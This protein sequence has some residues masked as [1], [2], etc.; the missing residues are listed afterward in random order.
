M[1]EVNAGEYAKRKYEQ[2]GRLAQIRKAIR[3]IRQVKRMSERARIK[4]MYNRSR[5]VNK[6][7]EKA[8]RN[9]R[10]EQKKLFK[11]IT[12][13]ANTWAKNSVALGSFDTQAYKK[14]RQY[15]ISSLN[16]A[17][18]FATKNT[19]GARVYSAGRGLR[20]TAADFLK[21]RHR[22]VKRTGRFLRDARMSAAQAARLGALNSGSIFNRPVARG[23]SLGMHYGGNSQKI[24]LRAQ[25]LAE[26][27]MK[28]VGEYKKYLEN[29]AKEKENRLKAQASAARAATEG[30]LGN[31]NR[32]AANLA[33][34][35]ARAAALQA[36]AQEVA[37]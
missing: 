17:A 8:I 2:V 32:N 18:E 29:L 37:P 26:N 15:Y 33:A 11:A 16:R 23:V 6:N 20:A 12:N 14:Y 4:N 34:A 9:S 22:N 24:P 21:R 1:S 31:V 25:G 7:L 19:F 10:E 3:G 35:Q 13:A 5:I 36:E 28:R 27:Y 30:A